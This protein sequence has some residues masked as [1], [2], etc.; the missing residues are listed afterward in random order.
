MY[1]WPLLNFLI[2]KQN[3]IRQ[4]KKKKRVETKPTIFL[5]KMVPRPSALPLWWMLHIIYALP[6]MAGK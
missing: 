2:I 6:F 3:N 4:K 1:I 5:G